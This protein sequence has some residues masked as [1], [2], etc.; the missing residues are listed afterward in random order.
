MQ[1]DKIDFVME[2]N[3][4]DSLLK[5]ARKNDSNN[6][7]GCPIPNKMEMPDSVRKSFNDKQELIEKMNKVFS[8]NEKLDNYAKSMLD[9][10]ERNGVSRNMSELI[11]KSY[12]YG[13]ND[14]LDAATTAFYHLFKT[15][16]TNGL[17]EDSDQYVKM[18]EDSIR[19]TKAF[20]E[21]IIE[22]SKIEEI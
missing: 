10:I 21:M 7:F 22:I 14:V 13:A 5:Q 8:E 19:H 11:I 3:D 2:K 4:Y 15:I 18:E 12:T 16:L 6:Y 17:E 1:R 9:I 20:R